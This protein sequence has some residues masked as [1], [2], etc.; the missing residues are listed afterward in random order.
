MTKVKICGLSTK[1]A[2][3]AAVEAGADYIG[4]V[5][6]PSKR[7]VSF[8]KAHEL[9]QLIPPTVKIVGVFVQPNLKELETAISVVPLDFIQIHGN[10]DECLSHHISVPIIRAIQLDNTLGE[11]NTN[12]DYLLF[13]APNAGS[14]QLFDWKLLAHHNFEKPFFIAGGLT[15]DNVA[16]AQSLFTPYAVDVSSGV[17]TNGQKDVEKIKAFI[18]RVKL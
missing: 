1:E 18:E 4:F 15:V 9:A 6:A 14:G 5:F 13:D 2:V 8:E 3:Y 12:A 11:L 16:E 10:W 7:R 17:E